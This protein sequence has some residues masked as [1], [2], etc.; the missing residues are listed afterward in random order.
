LLGLL[1]SGIVLP[2]GR[3]IFCELHPE[4]SKELHSMM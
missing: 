3:D 4:V 1:E 2:V